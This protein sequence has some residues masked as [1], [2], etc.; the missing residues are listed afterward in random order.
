[1]T[2]NTQAGSNR[3]VIRH[4]LFVQGDMHALETAAI[5]VVGNRHPSESARNKLLALAQSFAQ[6]GWVVV[7]GLAQGVDAAAHR[8]HYLLLEQ[9][10]QYDT[11][12]I[13]RIH[14]RTHHSAMT[15]LVMEVV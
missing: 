3:L 12:W 11:A 2:A 8:G 6:Q 5:S 15:L 14:K 7:S 10:L 9:L 1:M 4:C 13:T